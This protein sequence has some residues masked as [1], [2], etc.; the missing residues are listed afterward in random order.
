MHFHMQ[1]VI[2]NDILHNVV[3]AGQFT[4]WYH[5]INV[6][7]IEIVQSF[8]A[9][10]NGCIQ[11]IQIYGVTLHYCG[12]ERCCG[13]RRNAAATVNGVMMV[14]VVVVGVVVAI[15]AVVCAAA[16]A[17]IAICCAR[18]WCHG[19]R[20]RRKSCTFVDI[21]DTCSGDILVLGM[22]DRL[23]KCMEIIAL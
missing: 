10:Q 15:V 6:G 17:A 13:A 16:A 2:A 1:H 14:V 9:F 12:L 5:I 23:I 21:I 3:V 19:S 4:N 11:T 8:V 20:V 18:W 7:R 22:F